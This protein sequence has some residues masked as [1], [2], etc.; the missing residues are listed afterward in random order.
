MII[1]KNLLDLFILNIVIKLLFFLCIIY[2]RKDKKV[3]YI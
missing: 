3:I 1:E 2:Y